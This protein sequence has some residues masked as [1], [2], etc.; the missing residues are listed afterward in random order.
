[1]P[2]DYLYPAERRLLAQ[3]DAEIAETAG[4]AKALRQKR[5]NLLAKARVRR[6]RDGGRA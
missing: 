2:D 6:A 3:I 1:M 4:K 5:R